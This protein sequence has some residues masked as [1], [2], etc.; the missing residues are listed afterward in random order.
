MGKLGL[1]KVRFML[2][3][4]LIMSDSMIVLANETSKNIVI[5]TNHG[6]YAGQL[7]ENRQIQIALPASYQKYPNQKYPVLYVLDGETQFAF[8]SAV[9]SKLSKTPYPDI[10]EMIVV[11][12]VNTERSRDLTPTVRQEKTMSQE[13]ANKI[14]GATGGNMAFF[15][16]LENDVMNHIEKNYRTTGYN[17]LIGHSFGG[18]SALNHLLNGQKNIQAYI[19]HDPSIWWD[20]EVMLK[21]Y[22]AFKGKTFEN[23]KIFLTQVG[24]S[25]NTQNL[26]DHYQGIQA[27]NQYM[28]RQPFK[29]VD[30]Q[31]AQYEGEDHG[32]VPMKGNIDGL[33]YVFD[34]MRIN[35][36]DIPKTPQLVKETYAVFSQKM[37]FEF[38]PSE[39][40]L[41]SVWDYLQKQKDTQTMAAFKPYVLSIYPQGQLSKQGLKNI[42]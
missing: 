11:G 6:V 19:V 32:S 21:R 14:Q 23:K 40:Y 12:I 1:L 37:G 28:S 10:P 3:A 7:H 42:E 29:G 41:M 22:Q 30:Y 15:D 34:G 16:F 13:Q 20:S 35:I 24:Q 18:I 8:V 4:G 33:R 27:F 9:V 39:A 5:G 36:K 31:Y 25:E 38:L 26:S 2:M 17:V